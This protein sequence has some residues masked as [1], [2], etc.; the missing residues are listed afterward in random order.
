MCWLPDPD[1]N[2]TKNSIRSFSF[3]LVQL[4]IQWKEG[5]KSTIKWKGTKKQSRD[6]WWF[7]RCLLI[8][9]LLIKATDLLD[10]N[11]WLT[12]V[13][14]GSWFHVCLTFFHLQN[15]LL[16][17]PDDCSEYQSKD[18][19]QPA[20]GES[21]IH[22]GSVLSLGLIDK[23]KNKHMTSAGPL[24][25]IYRNKWGISFFGDCEL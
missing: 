15:F 3:V 19:P 17:I 4:I 18:L 7:I 9:L 23:S 6:N 11:E 1:H 8:C 25:S 5:N 14:H 16:C 20:M 21:V 13:V 12:N 10:T 24:S 22:V 2:C